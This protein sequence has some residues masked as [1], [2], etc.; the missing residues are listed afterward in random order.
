M[1][2]NIVIYYNIF[3]NTAIFSTDSSLNCMIVTGKKD[4]KWGELVVQ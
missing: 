1:L 4:Y 3:D 2:K